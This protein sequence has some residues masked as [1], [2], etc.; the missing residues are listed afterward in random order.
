MLGA[1]ISVGAQ[2]AAVVA[3]LGIDAVSDY[4]AY[5]PWIAA[6]ADALEVLPLKSHSIRALTRFLP[7]GLGT[8]VWAVSSIALIAIAIRTW[9]PE[10]P[11]R[12][13][14][15]LVLLASVLVNPH[16]IVY[17]AVLL[18]LPILWLGAAAARAGG[19][20]R[21]QWCR[22]VVVL[23]ASFLAFFTA[24]D[25]IGLVAMVVSVVAL[26]YVFIVSARFAPPPLMRSSAAEHRRLEQT[27][28]WLPSSC[29]RRDSRSE[30]PGAT[31]DIAPRRKA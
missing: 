26:L 24:S 25:S 28:S 30:P 1:A 6:H 5:V 11:L 4:V 20:D 22:A 18:V 14:L 17:D 10:V 3:V 19:R 13:R 7:F 27:N 31:K 21:D 29:P 23:F 9:R 15:G 12:L 8:P 2:L 16:A